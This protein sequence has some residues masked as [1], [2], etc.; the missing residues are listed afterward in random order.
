MGLS[1]AEM[2]GES[3]PS[4]LTSSL[5]MKR[6]IIPFYEHKGHHHLPI[7]MFQVC[8]EWGVRFF[9]LASK[10][11]MLTKQPGNKKHLRKSSRKIGKHWNFQHLRCGENPCRDIKEHADF[12]GLSPAQ[13][14]LLE[15]QGFHNAPGETS[16]TS[17]KNH[18][19]LPHVSIILILSHSQS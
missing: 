4:S 9:L 11:K 8:F 19:V 15:F 2:P 3:G 1:V 17:P 18:R 7:I 14:E 12:L 6:E 10:Q 16:E 5:L 13:L